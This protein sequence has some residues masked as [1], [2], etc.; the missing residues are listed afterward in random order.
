MEYDTRDRPISRPRDETIA[1]DLGSAARSCLLSCVI[2]PVG[3]TG[4]SLGAW[5]AGTFAGFTVLS[6]HGT[7][8]WFEL[9]TRDHAA[10]VEF[11]RTVFSWETDIVS[12]TDEFRYSTMRDPAGDSEQV[13]ASIRIGA[14]RGIE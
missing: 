7:P 1:M 11:Y 14:D 8:S 3:K 10:A 9:H 5:Q 4:A 13:A 6:E 12:D 2:G